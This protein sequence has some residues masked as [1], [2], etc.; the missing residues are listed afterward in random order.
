MSSRE[1]T[2]EHLVPACMRYMM[3]LQHK[4]AAVEQGGLCH[5]GYLWQVC[6]PEVLHAEQG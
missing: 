5:L 2:S 3:S 6:A 1:L 4:E